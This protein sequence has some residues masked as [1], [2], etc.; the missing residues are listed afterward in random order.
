[1]FAAAQLMLIY[2]WASWSGKSAFLDSIAF[3]IRT[4]DRIGRRPIII[5]GSVGL[6]VS[7]IWFGA[8]SS[9]LELMISRAL[10]VFIRRSRLKR[11][12]HSLILISWHF[13]RRD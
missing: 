4:L 6:V 12:R 8:S 10:G 3:S 11:L 1:M 2:Q 9:F 5:T 7:T 13:W